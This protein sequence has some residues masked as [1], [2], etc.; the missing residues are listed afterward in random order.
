L[1][2]GGDK[3]TPSSFSKKKKGRGKSRGGRSIGGLKRKIRNKQQ[4]RGKKLE[5]LLE[6]KLN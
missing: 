2:R 1:R 6:E 4:R 5:K 3:T